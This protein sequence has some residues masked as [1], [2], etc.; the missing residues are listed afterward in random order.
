MPF[1]QQTFVNEQDEPIYISIEPVPECYE[2][3][4]GDRLT[5]VYEV[6]ERGD[7]LNVHFADGRELIIWPATLIPQPVVLING[8]SAEGRSWNFKHR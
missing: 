2:L 5:L 1:A 3:E 7:V 6:P 8:V 4:P